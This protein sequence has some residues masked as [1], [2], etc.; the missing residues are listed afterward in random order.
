VRSTVGYNPT[1][2]R[3]I[4]S[5]EITSKKSWSLAIPQDDTSSFLTEETE[6]NAVSQYWGWALLFTFHDLLS[7]TFPI[8]IQDRIHLLSLPYTIPPARF[9]IDLFSASSKWASISLSSTKF[10][11]H[12]S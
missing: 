7:P 2:W 8:A 6:K 9:S 10:S 3:A 4:F 1:R 12:N 11:Q 5:H